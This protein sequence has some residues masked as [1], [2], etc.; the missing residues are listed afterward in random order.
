[1]NCLF[2]SRTFTEA[3]TKLIKTLH[4]STLPPVTHDLTAAC[5]ALARFEVHTPFI[6]GSNSRSCFTVWNNL[7]SP[8]YQNPTFKL[9]MEPFLPTGVLIVYLSLQQ[10]LLTLSI[11]TLLGTS[12]LIFSWFNL[13]PCKNINSSRTKL[14]YISTSTA[15][16]WA[17]FADNL[18][19]AYMCQVTRLW[20]LESYCQDIMWM[21]KILAL[22][23]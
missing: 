19:I 8:L 6:P 7:P 20:I 23:Y 13:F 15:Q 3:E 5:K 21:R 14:F 10:P 17:K 12:Y 18:L 9:Q 11:F 2:P 4:P 22:E 16:I 1:M